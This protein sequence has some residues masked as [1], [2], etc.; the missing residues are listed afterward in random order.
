MT[1]DARRLG[2]RFVSNRPILK[3]KCRHFTNMALSEASCFAVPAAVTRSRIFAFLEFKLSG[4]VFFQA[5]QS[6]NQS[7]IIVIIIDV[8]CA[9]KKRYI[10]GHISDRKYEKT[11]IAIQFRR[12][13]RVKLKQR[14]R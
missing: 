9:I 11:A 7:I 4:A 5:F 2:A 1:V 12:P 6:I 8:S 3:N 14:N 10:S 13:F